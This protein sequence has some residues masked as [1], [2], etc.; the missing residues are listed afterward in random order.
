[1]WTANQALSPTIKGVSHMTIALDVIRAGLDW[2]DPELGW[3]D[4]ELGWADPE[5]D[6]R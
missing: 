5:L 1:M 6:E 3:A 4:P 2:A